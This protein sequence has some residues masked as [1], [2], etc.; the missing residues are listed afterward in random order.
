MDFVLELLPYHLD[1]QKMPKDIS[2]IEYHFDDRTERWNV[3]YDVSE[4]KT[5]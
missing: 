2:E 3:T 4:T 1:P 5:E